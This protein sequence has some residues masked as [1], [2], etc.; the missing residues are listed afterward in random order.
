MLGN[1][2]DSLS[3]HP[4]KDNWQQLK[5]DKSQILVLIRGWHKM[6]SMHGGHPVGRRSTK[7]HFLPMLPDA[8]IEFQVRSL[9]NKAT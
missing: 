9:E 4:Q 8:L 3:L 2:A 1:I 7:H 6:L 5:P